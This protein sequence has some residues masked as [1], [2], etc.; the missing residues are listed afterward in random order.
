M[1]RSV[2]DNEEL[3]ARLGELHEASFGWACSCC[4]WNEADAEDVL[5]STYVKVISGRARF[6]GR[7]AFRTWLFGVIRLTASE[8]RRR[9]RSLRKKEDR[10]A[11]DVGHADAAVL[12][13]E[14]PAERA[15][16]ARIVRSAVETLPE[17]QREVLHLVFYEDMTIREAADVMA[18]SIGSARVHYDRAKKKLRQ[19]L[20]EGAS[21]GGAR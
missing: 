7:S 11:T 6:D 1:E 16:R 10:F 18:V 13:P 19:L 2:P 4:G 3:E 15:E 21:G 8:Q 5:Q 17:R 12:R 20:S 14:D 9:I